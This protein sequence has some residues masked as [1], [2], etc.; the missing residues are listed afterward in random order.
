MEV[1]ALLPYKD[2]KMVL[3]EKRNHAFLCTVRAGITCKIQGLRNK[4]KPVIP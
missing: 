3:L 1:R 4:K 2:R